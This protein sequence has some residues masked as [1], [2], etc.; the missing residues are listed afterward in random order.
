VF[1]YH[2]IWHSFVVAAGVCHYALIFTL[3]RAA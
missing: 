1:G 2:E 3:V